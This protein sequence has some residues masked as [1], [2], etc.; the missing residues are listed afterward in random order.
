VSTVPWQLGKF[1]CYDLKKVFSLAGMKSDREV[2]DSSLEIPADSFLLSPAYQ[3]FLRFHQYKE[4]ILNGG[5]VDPDS[6]IASNPD[7]YQ[8]YE[9]AGNE[10]FEKKDYHRA[11]DYYRQALTKVIATKGEEEYIR[12]QIRKAEEKAK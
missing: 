9:L 1:V 8:A 11:A 10:F 2:S 4:T 12:N 5:T 7:F 3:G 6:L